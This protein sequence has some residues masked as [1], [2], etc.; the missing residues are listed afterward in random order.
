MTYLM[1]ST[2][3]GFLLEASLGN[4]RAKLF[5]MGCIT[6]EKRYQQPVEYLLI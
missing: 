2:E 3:A 4:I 1:V 6:E 5:R